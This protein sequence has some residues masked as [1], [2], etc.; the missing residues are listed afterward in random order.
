MKSE[1]AIERDKRRQTQEYAINCD[2]TTFD[3]P[4]L[5]SQYLSS[6]I[7]ASFLSCIEAGKRIAVKRL[8]EII[9][10]TP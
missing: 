6:R 8:E 5:K 1:E 7:E 3:G 9:K 4:L 2:T 10:A